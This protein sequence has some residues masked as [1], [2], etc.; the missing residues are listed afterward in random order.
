MDSIIQFLSETEWFHWVTA[1]IAGA[2]AFAAASPTPKKGT[3]LSKVYNI[4]DI[5]AVNIGKA[6]DKGE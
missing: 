5:L 2:S 3:F 4:V 1:V 6:K